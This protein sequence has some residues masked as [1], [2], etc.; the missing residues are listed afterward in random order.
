M[1]AMPLKEQKRVGSSAPAFVQAV[2]RARDINRIGSDPVPVL[3]TL[4]E[5][6]DNAVL[7][8][9]CLWYA[10]NEGVTVTFQPTARRKKPGANPA[11]S[12]NKK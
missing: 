2:E 1:K 9:L 12:G 11:V 7:L 3:A 5:F 6:Y 4:D 10:D 8:Y